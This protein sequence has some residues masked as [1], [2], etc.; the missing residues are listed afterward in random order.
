MVWPDCLAVK[1]TK[2]NLIWKVLSMCTSVY[3]LKLMLLTVVLMLRLMFKCWQ[4]DVWTDRQMY[5]QTDVWTDRQMY[6]QTD[7]CMNR[8]TDVWTDRQMYEQTDRCMNIQTDVWTDRQMY[9]QTDRCMNRQTDVWIDRQM[10]EQT[11]RW[12]SEIGNTKLP[13]QSNPKQLQE[14]LQCFL[15]HNYVFP[16]SRSPEGQGHL[17][18]NIRSSFISHL[19]KVDQHFIGCCIISKIFQSSMYV[20]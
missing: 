12:A 15:C 19:K 11:D 6:E 2:H 1:V 3:S 13:K 18:V 16:L 5:E 7:I 10:Y 17:K 14:N 20:L 8:Q 4:T 9:V